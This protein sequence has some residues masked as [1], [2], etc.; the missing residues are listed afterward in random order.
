MA[1]EYCMDERRIGTEDI[2]PIRLLKE[3]VASRARGI[4]VTWRL[5]MRGSRDNAICS[6]LA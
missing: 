4:I 1:Y 3:S 2:Y 6:E 5:V